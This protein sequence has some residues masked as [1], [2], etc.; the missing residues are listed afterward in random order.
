[1]S[2][3]DDPTT[4]EL[5]ALQADREEEERRRAAEADLPQERRAAERRAEKAAYLEAKLAEQEE[6]LGE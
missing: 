1:L 4:G 5:R 3:D 2:P 6:T